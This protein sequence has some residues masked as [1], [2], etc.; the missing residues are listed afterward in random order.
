MIRH[1]FALRRDAKGAT[2]LEFALIAPVLSLLLIGSL[3]IGHTLYMKTVLQGV[4]QKT[5]RDSGLEAGLGKDAALDAKVTSQVKTLAYG[6][7]L[8]FS[9]RY[10]RTFSDAAA[11]KAEPFTDTNGDGKCDSGE[12]FEDHNRNG[13]RDADGAD[14]GQG[15]AKDSVLY[16]VTVDYPRLFPMASLAGLP[17]I[18]TVKG[19]M[20]LANQ[21]YGDQGSYGAMVV[22]NCA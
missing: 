4:I 21:P 11:A 6:A 15:G 5:A 7:T 18:V 8:S 20:I 19:V 9:R 12:P 16:T 17:E 13:V 3:D 10:Y 14:N 2:A 1:P 22:R